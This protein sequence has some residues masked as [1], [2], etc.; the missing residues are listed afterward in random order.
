[1]KKIIT[2][3]ILLLTVSTTLLSK[4]KKESR[5]SWEEIEYNSISATIDENILYIFSDKQCENLDIQIQDLDGAVVY[6]NKVSLQVGVE[7]M[8]PVSNLLKEAYQIVLTLNEKT[9][10]LG[11]SNVNRLN[12]PFSRR[13]Y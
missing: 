9:L 8:I 3:F 2:I 11:L 4:E 13:I 6:T 10:R 7:F 12:D 5:H 1:M